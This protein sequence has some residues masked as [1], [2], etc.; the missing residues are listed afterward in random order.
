MDA[1][2]DIRHEILPEAELFAVFNGFGQ[3]FL[4]T[5]GLEDGDAVVTL[6]VAYFTGDAHAVGKR[7]QEGDVQL[8]D[9][10]PQFVQFQLA[11]WI[12]RR[13]VA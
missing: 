4:P 2:E 1:I 8:V 11:F 6:Q 12:F 5:G 7:R 9:G 13:L 3:N 10:K